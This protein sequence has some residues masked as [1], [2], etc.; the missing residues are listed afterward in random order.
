MKDALFQ[1]AQKDVAFVGKTAADGTVVVSYRDGASAEAAVRAL[2]G[3]TLVSGGPAISASVVTQ[4]ATANRAQVD[5]TGMTD[6]ADGGT[7]GTSSVGGGMWT[8]G[9]DGSLEEVLDAAPSIPYELLRPEGEIENSR[10][11]PGVPGDE[12]FAGA[13]VSRRAMMEPA[14]AAWGR[15]L[16]DGSLV[17]PESRMNDICDQ[18]QSLDRGDGLSGYVQFSPNG[19]VSIVQNMSSN[20]TK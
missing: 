19:N 9:N 6:D 13:M 5:W 18:W 17:L 14:D 15:R 12:G 2:A 1:V 7:M 4:T 11:Q 20:S 8:L 3:R 10:S 16:E